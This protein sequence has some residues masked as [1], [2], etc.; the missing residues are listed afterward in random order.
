M[1]PFRAMSIE[2]LL[3]VCSPEARLLAEAAR[4]TIVSVVPAASERLRSGWGLIGY[5]APSYFAFI[6]PEKSRARIGFEW[7]VMLAD[8]GGLL[9]GSGSQVRY[10]TIRTP[11]DGGGTGACPVTARSSRDAAP[12]QSSEA[13]IFAR[14]VASSFSGCE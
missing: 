7:G 10:V 13:T 11:R 8:P 1:I 3:S 9:E 2:E 14:D 4:K 6:V 5:N 12:V